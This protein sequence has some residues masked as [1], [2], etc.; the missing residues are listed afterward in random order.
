[1]SNP[2]IR[3]GA[4]GDIAGKD[5][6]A[7][8]LERIV[9]DAR[10][11]RL[12]DHHGYALQV[13][14]GHVDLFAVRSNEKSR[15]GAR[16]HLFRVE[17]D[18]IILDLPELADNQSERVRVIAVGG[19]GAE[20]LIVPRQQIKEL[21]LIATWIGS[22][23]TVLAG[24]N[25]DWSIREAELD[26]KSEIAPRER[27]R[28]FAQDI[29][30]AS[31]AAG[32]IRLMGVE[33][34]YASTS[35]PALLASGMWIEAGE[36]ASAVVFQRDR[37]SSDNDVWA[38][39]DQF[40]LCAMA[41]IQG[42]LRA[43]AS[44][45]AQRLL[46]RVETSRTQATEVLD[47]LS[48]VIVR[49]SV[50]GPQST[51][52]HDPLLAVSHMVGEAIDAPIVRPP[53]RTPGRQ[54]FGDL[55][56]IARAS[57]LRVRR[58]LLRAN[59]WNRDV[60][61]LVAWHGDERD[62]VALIPASHRR[63]LMIEPKS[64]MTRSV[65]E[66][67]AAELSTEAAMLYRTLPARPLSL[68][69]L[70]AFSVRAAPA[71]LAR[72][73]LSAALLGLLSLA[74]PLIVYELV[75]SVL[76]RT[77]LDQLAFCAAALAVTAIAV[78]GVQL[79]QG[80][81]MLRLEGV[82]DWKLQAAVID[83][84][85]RLPASFFRE[86]TV[87]DLVTRSLGID[88]IR[89]IFTGQTLRSLLAGMFCWFSFIP[90]F[91]F[92]SRLALIATAL[93]IV[94]AAL[95][96]AVSAVRLHHET[97]HFNLQG[98]LEGFILQLLAGI[99][100]LR[101]AAAT[102]R[103]LAGWTT[104]FAAQ[105]RHFIAS[106][107]AANALSVVET[108]FPI[109][110]TLIIFAAAMALGSS[111]TLDLGAFLAF[112]TAFGQAIASVGEWAT[113]ISSSLIAI[114]HLSRIRPLIE[115][116][117]EFSDDRRSGGELSGAFELSRVTFRYATGG[118]PVLDTITLRVAAGEYLAL[119]GPSGSGKS[120]VFRLLLGFEK[121]E[122]GAIFFDGKAIDT[123]DISALRRQMG[124]VLQNGKL[125]SGSIYE[126]IC[127]GV[128]LPLDQVW[129]A[130]RLAGLEADLNAM[131]MGIHTMIAE[132]VSTISGGQ[133]QRLMIARAIARRPRILLFDE[134]TS[135][136]DNQSQAIVSDSLGRLNVTRVVIAHRLSTVREADRIVV[137][138]E[139]KIV[140]TG[141]FAELSETSGL[142]ADLVQ[143]QLL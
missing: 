132:G 93:T 104:Q 37:P 22:V 35:P 45:E 127:A 39:I 8:Q 36:R 117:L 102:I 56:E 82:L 43:D 85:L 12:L 70:L 6:A 53:E 64:G 50:S 114:P 90:M 32:S 23:G 119:V 115:N 20:A 87:G 109:I 134:A 89:R 142:F 133:R 116:N 21:G 28:G 65:N 27:R 125:A 86:Y 34:A 80:V 54:E 95:I 58:T 120:T 66:E 31:V 140:Q 136:L 123:L 97:R 26:Q 126:N 68:W 62:P 69:N 24:D 42:R 15:K 1:M 47:R 131:P 105:K 138:V 98:K 129:E 14:A 16:H 61:P 137:L 44:R 128:P 52:A 71:D 38:A 30:W 46:R 122:S 40:H 33:P 99:G 48:A 10:V 76:P 75:N 59:W 7:R 79:M 81:A 92:D 130:A 74:A 124:V 63:Y 3:T 77:E 4:L 135:S 113:A 73:T 141:T 17:T 143:R 41:C 5:R 111:L 83:R 112:F 29:L 103:A 101:V 11:P 25:V 139:G 108:S 13:V 67:I 110:A 9:L 91:Y 18:E 107:R 2:R 57:R 72:I 94:R 118:P 51:D 121:V 88:A 84:L 106:Q 60:G 19:P 55:V 96:V 78:A 100:K 49:R